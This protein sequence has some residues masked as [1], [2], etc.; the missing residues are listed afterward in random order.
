MNHSQQS[1]CWG[2][3]NLY[4]D[5]ASVTYVESSSSSVAPGSESAIVS[6]MAT[7]RASACTRGKA[8]TRSAS[9]TDALLRRRRRSSS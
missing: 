4:A 1:A 5:F 8:T 2:G 9:G 7:A 3:Q 6:T